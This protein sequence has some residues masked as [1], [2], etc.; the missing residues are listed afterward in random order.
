MR[1]E[2]TWDISRKGSQYNDQYR[3]W[4]CL[5]MWD[6]R[7]CIQMAVFVGNRMIN[8]GMLGYSILRE[9]RVGTPR[10]QVF[11]VSRH[12]TIG[13][14]RKING[15]PFC[16]SGNSCLATVLPNHSYNYV[17][18]RDEQPPSPPISQSWMTELNGTSESSYYSCWWGEPLGPWLQTHTNIER[19]ATPCSPE[20][21]IR[22]YHF[23]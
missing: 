5:N 20:E 15:K 8:N 19:K 4:F 1:Y 21:S 3:I 17:S 11:N 9:N 14:K 13:S 16:H 10:W 22:H 12:A 18:R 6:T 2:L 7:K 23:L